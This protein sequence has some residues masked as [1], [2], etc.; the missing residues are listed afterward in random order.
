MIKYTKDGQY[1]TYSQGIVFT[2]IMDRIRETRQLIKEDPE[3]FNKRDDFLA[4]I[5][6]KSNYI[7]VPYSDLELRDII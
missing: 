5:I 1:F 7:N 2:W 4:Q 6:K 3:Q